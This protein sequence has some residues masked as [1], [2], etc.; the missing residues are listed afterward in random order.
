[1]IMSRQP[2]GS[3]QLSAWRRLV[4]NHRRAAAFGACT[5]ALGFAIIGACLPRASEPPPIASGRYVLTTSA[6]GIATLPATFVDSAG[7]TQRIFGDT[8]ELNV[9]NATYTEHGTVALLNSDGSAQPSQSFVI[10][11][12]AAGQIDDH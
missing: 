2:T 12:K 1:M 4:A 3:K 10:G 11:P 7:R 6:G 9:T 5:L 8:I